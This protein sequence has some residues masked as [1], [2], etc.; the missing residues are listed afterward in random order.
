MHT[1]KTKSGLNW[2]EKQAKSCLSE[3]SYDQQQPV[4]NEKNIPKEF[5]KTLD[6]ERL[7]SFLLL[8]Y[9]LEFYMS[10]PPK[11]IT[12]T[13]PNSNKQSKNEINTKNQSRKL[14]GN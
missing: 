6:F 9:C 4:F 12:R 2:R 3:I 5:M 13:K 10:I 14:N 8:D 7:T 11:Y 1:K